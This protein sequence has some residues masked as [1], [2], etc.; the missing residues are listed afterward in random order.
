[1]KKIY[2]QYLM[3]LLVASPAAH[4]LD[5]V[6]SATGSVRKSE[7]V[8]DV[9]TKV[10]K[11]A[12]AEAI[13][14]AIEHFKTTNVNMGILST[15]TDFQMEQ[16]LI[17]ALGVDA[18]VQSVNVAYSDCGQL[19]EF[20]IG[21]K[22]TVTLSSSALESDGWI[23]KQVSRFNELNDPSLSNSEYAGALINSTGKE[24]YSETSSSSVSFSNN[25]AQNAR[26][27]WYQ[28]QSKAA[29]LQAILTSKVVYSTK[30]GQNFIT[31]K[32]P[33]VA[34]SDNLGSQL[35]LIKDSHFYTPE[36]LKKF[37]VGTDFLVGGDSIKEDFFVVDSKYIKDEMTLQIPTAPQGKS[38]QLE[39]SVTNSG[40]SE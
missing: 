11:E 36:L 33:S 35:K 8:Y 4:A 9:K 3:L 29:L 6:G 10:V 23:E 34:T 2:Y 20:C 40:E 22:A 12:Q 21:L 24:S 18:K 32:F 39:F 30:D 19:S 26:M 17:L 13:A 38:L 14:K 15:L 25:S 37:V 28:M 1:M 5:F 7:T 27:S 31:V 16:T